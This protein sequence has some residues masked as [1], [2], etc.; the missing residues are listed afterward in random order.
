[1]QVK[2]IQIPVEIYR[3]L[4]S[5]TGL[6]D[7]STFAAEKGLPNSLYSVLVYKKDEAIGMGRIV[8]DGGCFCQIVDVCVLPKFQGY[9]V[10]KVIMEHL[11]KYI[12][13]SLPPSCYISI[14][15]D[16]DAHNLYS[17]YGFKDTLPNHKGMFLKVF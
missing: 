5:E 3:T 4:R 12:Q 9:G 16:G 2:E 10:G 8:G 15:A 14:I 11:C 6:S 7:K 13:D 17:K 1:M